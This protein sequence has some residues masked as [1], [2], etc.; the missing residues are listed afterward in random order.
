MTTYRRALFLVEVLK[1]AGLEVR[2][3]PDWQTRGRPKSTGGFDPRAIIFHHDASAK[4]PSPDEAK[5][6]ALTGRPPKIPAPLAHCWVGTDG[7]WHVLASGRTN[8]AGLG[9]G[10]GRIPKDSG[11]TYAIGVETDHTSKENWAPGQLEAITIG[12]AALAD[13]MSIDPMRSVCGHREYAPGRKIDP[14]RVDMDAFRRDVA[15]HMRHLRGG[16]SHPPPHAAP[17]TTSRVDLSDVVEAAVHDPGH[18]GQKAH[19]LQVTTVQKALVA[20]DLLAQTHVSG[21]FDKATKD[22]YTA[23]QHACG[24]TGGSTD[25]GVPGWASLTR[26][27]HRNAFTVVR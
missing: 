18:P 23:W 9:S 21:S 3:M 14:S 13:A 17:A 15:E 6:I 26:L 11:N 19:P 10:F 7:V 8:H 12:F 4:G 5:F 24:F 16:R 22:A 1:R 27:G 2:S 20:E 25:D